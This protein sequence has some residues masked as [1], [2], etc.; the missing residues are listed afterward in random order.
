MTGAA[1]CRPSEGAQFTA[2][3]Q[4]GDVSGLSAGRLV[5]PQV[6]LLEAAQRGVRVRVLV[7]SVERGSGVEFVTQASRRDGFG[8]LLDG[9]IQL[10][11]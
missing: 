7:P 1:S 9:G 5:R 11:E 3:G 10:H 8:P 6:D 2:G 4:R